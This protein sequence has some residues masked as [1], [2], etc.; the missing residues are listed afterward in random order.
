MKVQKGCSKTV[1]I[2]SYAL[3][4]SV[5]GVTYRHILNFVKWLNS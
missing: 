4:V 3:E 2:V 5:N 1:D